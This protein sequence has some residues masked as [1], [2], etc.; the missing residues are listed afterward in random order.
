MPTRAWRF[1]AAAAASVIVVAVAAFSLWRASERSSGPPSVAVLPFAGAGSGAEGA[2]FTTGFHDAIISQL[3]RI[4]G[5]KVISRT[6]VLGYRAGERDHDRIAQEL[7]VRHLVEGSVRREGERLRVTARLFV[8]DSGQQLWS[9]DYDRSPADIFTVQA[10]MARQIARAID[11]RLTMEEEARLDQAPTQDLVAYDLYL[12]AV[13]V[14]QRS[15][16]DKAAITQA[17]A[18]LDEALARDPNFALAHAMASRLQMTIY[19]VI[20]EY[21][22]ARLPKAQEHAQRAIELAPNLAEPHLAMAL[23]W[24][25]GNREYDKALGSLGDALALEPNSASVSFLTGSIYRRLARWDVSISAARRAA[26]L[27]P[28]NPRNLQVYADVL[29]A[30]RYFKDADDVL[31]QL[32]SVSPRSPLAFLMRLQNQARWTGGAGDAPVDFARFEAKEDPYCLARL[33]E[34][35]LQMLQRKF[36]EAAAT[37]LAC[38]GDVIGALHN[39]P[40]PKQQFAAI[41]EHFAGN[42]AGAKTHA[43]VARAALQKRLAERP[44][45]PLSRIALAQMLA[46]LGD[47]AAALAEADRAVADAPMTKDAIVAAELRDQVAALHAHLG[48]HDRALTELTETLALPYG[49]YAPLVQLNPFWDGLRDDARFKQ[50]VA[51]SLPKDD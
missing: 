20:G 46:I 5:L 30:N 21:D 22:K 50:L 7:G 41:A 17:L 32:G 29:S 2:Y 39:V 49:S 16:P 24:Y 6:S 23:Y 38:P 18:W 14:E 1:Y 47:P 19:W 9:A 25:W 26:L 8:A 4:Q 15:P 27:D 45:L 11:A 40:S 28:R 35:E 43:E 10:D 51:D 42:A 44:D 13:E 48:E 3:A 34:H 12:R 31:A 33:A 36:T 37:I